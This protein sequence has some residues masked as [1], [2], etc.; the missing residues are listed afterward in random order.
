MRRSTTIR[1]V[2]ALLAEMVHGDEGRWADVVLYWNGRALP[3]DDRACQS[4]PGDDTM[5]DRTTRGIFCLYGDINPIVIKRGE[6][7]RTWYW[8]Y[9]Q[10]IYHQAPRHGIDYPQHPFPRA[11]QQ[12]AQARAPVQAPAWQPAAAAA[13]THAPPHQDGR[14]W[15]LWR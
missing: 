1:D 6:E 4:F 10:L 13:S 9:G 15:T 8:D 11:G 2:C 5:V 12:P 14:P 7:R 3:Y